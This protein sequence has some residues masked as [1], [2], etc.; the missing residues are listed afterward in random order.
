ML[1]IGDGL[2]GNVGQQVCMASMLIGKTMKTLLT[3]CVLSMACVGCTSE[4]ERHLGTWEGKMDGEKGSFTFQKT[5]FMVIAGKDTFSGKYTI[6]YTKTPIWLDFEF[7]VPK[8]ADSFQGKGPAKGESEKT[9]ASKTTS[10]TMKIRAIL[11]FTGDDTLRMVTEKDSEKPHP[12]TFEGAAKILTL[13]KKT[14]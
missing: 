3:V 11:E 2:M 12:T 7:E 9:P 1:V 13:T 8:S 14:N 4:D 10:E 5:T 6:D